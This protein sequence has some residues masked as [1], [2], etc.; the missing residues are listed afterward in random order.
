M[1]IIIPVII[2]GYNCS[3][4]GLLFK[5]CSRVVRLQK[6]NLLVNLTAGEGEESNVVQKQKEIFQGVLIVFVF[7]S[8]MFMIIENFE[9]THSNYPYD[10]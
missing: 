8:V 5:A 4:V 10:F 2:Y 9:I 3:K 6:L 7:S 1:V